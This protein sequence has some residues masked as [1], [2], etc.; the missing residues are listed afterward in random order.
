MQAVSGSRA[1]RMQCS[2]GVGGGNRSPPPRRQ[3]WKSRCAHGT[4]RSPRSKPVRE[5]VREC[6]FVCV[7]SASLSTLAASNAPP[8]EAAC[9]QRTC[10]VAANKLMLARLK[11]SLRNDSP[12]LA[13]ARAPARTHAASTA[14]RVNEQWVEPVAYCNMRRV[15]NVGQCRGRTYPGRC[16][17]RRS[18][19]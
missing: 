5:E 3:R 13:Y 16:A 6:V 1:R 18:R 11:Y 14:R 15:D 9:F 7:S 17:V 19:T 4:P 10:A 12:P 8:D 2:L